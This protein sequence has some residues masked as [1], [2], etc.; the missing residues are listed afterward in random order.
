MMEAE[1]LKHAK[2]HW[3]KGNLYFKEMVQRQYVSKGNTVTYME[4]EMYISDRKVVM[5]CYNPEVIDMLVRVFPKEKIKVWFSTESRKHNDR[6]YTDNT[7]RFVEVARLVRLE[8][9]KDEYS[10]SNGF[11]FK[12]NNEDF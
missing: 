4:V 3:Y 10:S 7:L 5:N 8:K 1:N 12:T 9:M 6:W 11:D 2:K